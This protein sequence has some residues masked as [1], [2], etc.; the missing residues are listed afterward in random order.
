MGLVKGKF[1]N[2]LRLLYDLSAP[3]CSQVPCLNSLIPSEE[4]FLKYASVDQ[5]I[6]SI[7]GAGEGAW[8]SKADI[9]DAFKLL[10]ILPSLWQWHGIKWRGFYCFATE[11]TFGS[12]AV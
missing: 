9:A 11:L 1:S 4:F 8:L 6:Q 3:H 7:I 5:A 10:P 12:L 2:K